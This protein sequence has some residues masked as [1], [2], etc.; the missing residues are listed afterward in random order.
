MALQV[1][2]VCI[3]ELRGVLDFAAQTDG[4]AFDGGE[5]GPARFGHIAREAEVFHPV[6]RFGELAQELAGGFEGAVDVPERARPAEAGELQARGGVAFGDGACLI[7]AHEE[8]GDAFRPGALEGGEAVGDLFDGGTEEVGQPFEIVAGLQGRGL[9]GAVGQE[10]GPGEVIGKADL[11]DVA[12]LGRGEAGE[13]ERGF[14]QL[15]L[16]QE[17]HLQ[18]E[19]EALGRACGAV[20][21]RQAL[22]RGIVAAGFGLVGEGDGDAA[23][24][25]CRQGRAGDVLRCAVRGGEMFG[26]AVDGVDVVVAVVEE[27]AHLLPRGGAEGGVFAAKRF[28]QRGEAFVGLAI[29]AVQVEEGAGQR[30][31]VGGGEAQVGQ[32]GRGGGEDG[33]CQ[34]LAHVGDEAFG[35]AHGQFGDVE[36]EFLCQGQ[37]HRRRDGAVVVFHLVEIGERDAQLVGKGFLGEGEA[38]A[39]FAQLGTGIEF[40]RGHVGILCKAAR[41]GGGGPREFCKVLRRNAPRVKGEARGAGG[42]R[43]QPSPRRRARRITARMEKSA[44]MAE[45]SISRISG[46][47]VAPSVR[48]VPASAASAAPPPIWIAPPRPEAVPASSGLIE[49]IPALALGSVMP[50]PRPRARVKPKKTKGEW[51]PA[52]VTRARRPMPMT[53]TMVPPRIMRFSPIRTEKRPAMKLPAA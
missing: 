29:G 53:Q 5:E 14:D 7:D 46:I 43:D 24:F 34:R 4:V 51:T 37:H 50:L 35:F 42:W 45:A 3:D 17:G 19:L 31:R 27:V 8:E 41:R 21:E 36:A 40:L 30:G 48:S 49:S 18:Q 52:R 39:D 47:S 16:G 32:G 1:Q 15:V 11:G 13:V 23:L 33:V 10:G 22:G 28:V 9:E 2:P 25:Q 12:R 20:R 38:G 6:G 44:R 26:G